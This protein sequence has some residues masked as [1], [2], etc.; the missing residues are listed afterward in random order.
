MID[1]RATTFL[2]GPDHRFPLN[3]D[4]GNGVCVAGGDVR[5]NFDRNWTWDQMHDMSN[6]AVR[7][8]NS[9]FTV[10]G[11]R[12][13][14]MT[15]GLR[16]IDGPFTIRQAWL[17]YIRDDCVENDHVQ[18]GLIE[19]SLFD[20]CY[21]GIS[22]RPSPTIEAEGYDGRD[23]VLTVRNTLI[24]LQPMRGPDGGGAS[25]YGH[26]PFFKWHD[27]ATKLALHNNVFMAEKSSRGNMGIPGRLESC[28]NNVMVWLGPGDYPAPLPSC[29]TVTRDR[30]VWDRAVADWK[31][32]HPHVGG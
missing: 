28:S 13:D 16:P 30:S 23:G 9:E 10:D 22:E 1:A 21:V 3:L 29:F 18:S 12:V 32:R 2:A 4:G 25:D 31:A 11:L 5:G 24:R 14:N 20:G 15:D 8:Q 19:D 17:S 6:T 7:F 27:L 26:G